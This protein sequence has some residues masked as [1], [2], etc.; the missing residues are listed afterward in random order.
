M[1]RNPVL[2]GMLSDRALPPVNRP[3]GSFS[4]V[5]VRRGQ[6]RGA[7]D[8]KNRTR[9]LHSLRG[10][11]MSRNKQHTIR[12]G[13]TLPEWPWRVVGKLAHERGIRF[14]LVGGAVRDTLL[15]RP[16][17][18]WDFAVDR[19]AMLLARAVGDALG[20]FFFPL[21]EERGTARVVLEAD[22]NPS[23]ELDFALL[24]A[25]SLEGDLAARDFTINA[26]AIDENQQLMDPLGGRRD[27]ETRC[28][29]AVN[30]DVFSDDPARLLRALRLEAE[31]D[32]ETDPR[33]ESWIRQDAALLA[34]PAEERLR[35][36]FVRGLTVSR[37]ASFILRLDH[38]DLLVHLMPDLIL[39]KGVSQSHPHRF[40]VW[41]HTLSVI[42]ML[43]GVIATVT[44]EPAAAGS[45][46]LKTVGTSAWGD[47]TR[48]VGQ[49]A[50]ALQHHLTVVVCDD[51]DRM[52]LL[53]LA[54]L[55][56]D[57]G[58]PQTQSVD[59]D[60]RIHFY[61]HE[62]VGARLAV[63]RLRT[64]RF[65]R[66][67][68]SR[69]RTMIQAHLRPAQLAREGKVTRRAIYRYFRDTGDAGVETVLLSLADHLAT[70][71]PNLREGRW[72]KRLETAAL[73][74]DHYFERP[75][76]SVSPQLPIDG[77]DLMRVLDIEPGP[78]V[79]RLLDLLREA[80]AAG[81]VETR[82]E[83]LELAQKSAR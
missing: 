36:E 28:I 72:A 25:P 29:R 9:G 51:R 62:L 16:L 50:G 55:L 64:L 59:E 2:Q 48:W 19:D 6:S 41:R 74:L 34:D 71:G 76:Q 12:S 49:F 35:D 18:D 24:R 26:M 14:W 43:E 83:I 54:A 20:G 3:A 65:G 61:G 13:V 39:L 21:D 73:L 78:E 11:A 30:R 47:L 79:G 82:E 31:L 60:D 58:K 37:A 70:W 52:L 7:G 17:H 10:R 5:A 63:A 57:I 38:L 8:P 44:G 1:G 23:L 15:G 32:F 69:V 66:R 46:R 42:E 22:G 27:L 77:H 56:H 67:E 75:Q 81:E 80:V 4:R 68:V 45:D 53:R 33:T 40:D